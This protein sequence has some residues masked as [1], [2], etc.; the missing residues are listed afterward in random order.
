MCVCVALICTHTSVCGQT[1]RRLRGRAFHFH[2][3]DTENVHAHLTHTSS[4]FSPNVTGQRDQASEGALSSSPPQTSARVIKPAPDCQTSN[5]HGKT[6]HS[7]RGW[8]GR[9]G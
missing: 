2:S 3:D 6:E 5:G 9:T 1:D 8:G 7:E 4:S